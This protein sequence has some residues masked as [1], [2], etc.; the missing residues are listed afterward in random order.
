MR[1]IKTL[2]IP[3]L[4]GVVLMIMLVGVADARPSARPQEQA[5]RVLTVGA[6]ACTPKSYTADWVHFYQFVYCA[7]GACNFACPLNFPAAGEQAV[8]A[9]N[10]KR[11][12]MYA[13]DPSGDAAEATFWLF[14]THPPSASYGDMA[15]GSSTNSPADPQTVMDTSIVGNPVYRVHGP[16]IHLHIGPSPIRVYGLFVHYTW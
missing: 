3:V 4:L 1:T 7:S 9:V 12:T 10:V 15:N 5:W 14:K 8:G 6:H 2:S 13:Y 16:Y 11:V